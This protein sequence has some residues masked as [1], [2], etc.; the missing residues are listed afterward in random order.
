MMSSL[1][2]SAGPAR[3]IAS[4][5]RI[6]CGR[7]PTTVRLSWDSALKV[8][9]PQVPSGTTPMLRWKSRNACS[10]STPNRPSTRPQSNPMSSS[11]CCSA[12]TSSPAISRAGTKNRIRSP[13]RQRASSRAWYVRGPTW[14][15]TEIPRCCWKARTARSVASSNKGT[16]GVQQLGTLALGEQPEQGQLGPDLGHCRPGVAPGIGVPRRAR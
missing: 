8:A 3:L 14:P 7:P 15:S 6:A 16:S 4:E 5:S 10:V 12:A 9:G 13:R 2:A 1:P 11:R